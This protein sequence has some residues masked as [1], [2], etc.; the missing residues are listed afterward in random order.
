MTVVL[1]YEV[2]RDVRN[3]IFTP[4]VG[5]P[6]M[7]APAPAVVNGKT[8][9]VVKTGVPDL[10]LWE[11]VGGSYL[12]RGEIVKPRPGTFD[13]AGMAAPLLI[14][15]DSTGTLHLYY[16]GNSSFTGQ[17]YSRIGYTTALASNPL[18]W[19]TP[20]VVLDNT[21]VAAHFGWA[22]AEDVGLWDM[23]EIDGVKTWYGHASI[24]S[25]GDYY[26]F[27]A[28]SSN[29]EDIHIV[30]SYAI[31]GDN[32]GWFSPA[33]FRGQD[34]VWRQVLSQGRVNG[35]WPYPWCLHQS[36][37][38]DGKK[39]IHQGTVFAQSNVPGSWDRDLV[40][41]AHILKESHAPYAA[42]VLDSQGRV[43]IFFS[44][45]GVP[46]DT[47][48]SGIA[49]WEDNEPPNC[50]GYVP[51]NLA[52][53]P[54]YFNFAGVQDKWFLSTDGRWYALLPS[55]NMLSWAG[56]IQGSPIIAELPTHY[57]SNT[58]LLGYTL[59]R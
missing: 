40:F 47:D 59:N 10:C 50:P 24:E 9:V 41:A 13:Q 22:Q 15:D 6:W 2:Q 23:V 26:L 46:T 8:L 12:Y 58:Y 43:Q 21:D 18:Q 44:G 49:Y 7:Y 27:R 56:T 11:E 5:H 32:G 39:W 25:G 48:R 30:D 45:R 36:A 3:P 29:W 57:Y 52:E 31:I 20:H 19:A 35:P 38:T 55:G 33:V 17:G 14:H 53:R 37:S 28:E 1:P 16:N 42:P 54:E 4:K 51:P 34:N